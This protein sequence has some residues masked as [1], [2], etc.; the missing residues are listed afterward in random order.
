LSLSERITLEHGSGGAL[1][2][3]LTEQLIYPILS[4][5]AYRELSD[6]TAFEVAGR[7]FITTDTYVVDPIFFPGGDIG[8]LG[9]FGTCNDLSVCGARPLY[10][11]IGLVLEEGFPT[12]DLRRVL[13]SIRGAA[14]QVGVRVISGDTKVVPA[15]KGGG[16]FLNTTGI[17]EAMGDYLLSVQNIREGDAV[18]VSGPVGGHGLAILAS[19]EGLKVGANLRSDC[20]PLFPLCEALYTLG[21]QLRFMRDATRGGVAAVLNEAVA[22]N[23]ECGMEIRETA[24]PI[25]GTVEAASDLLGL[26]PLEIANEGVMIAVV[27]PEVVEQALSL[28]RSF[29]IG[30]EACRV[31]AVSTRHP[32]R[33]VLETAV[34]GRRILDLPRGLLLPRIC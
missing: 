17:G 12:A 14:E 25:S 27:A 10:L 1:S 6:A 20:A 21:E 2:R 15:G 33:V 26:N 31:G 32:G 24:F 19:R 7:T 3:Q 23:R 34:G 29:Q 4:N 18:L 16:I 8:T 28:L 5:P 30:R 11:T 13:E 9:V 22:E